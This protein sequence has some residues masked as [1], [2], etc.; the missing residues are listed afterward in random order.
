MKYVNCLRNFPKQKF[1]VQAGRFS[2]NV[3]GGAARMWWRW[4]KI[5]EMNFL[6]DA[7]SAMRKMPLA[8]DITQHWKFATKENLQRCV[9]MTVE[10]SLEFFEAFQISS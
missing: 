10:D 8:K 5:I 4:M 7:R 3:K 2:F 1:V 6:P 9:D